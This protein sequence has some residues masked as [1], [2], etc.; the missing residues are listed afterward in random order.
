MLVLAGNWA[1]EMYKVT[2]KHT[3]SKL[4]ISLTGSDGNST[5]AHISYE[6]TAI[7]TSGNKFVEEFTDEWYEDLMV[8]W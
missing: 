7:G 2:P 3:V 8:E 1:L 6:I 5:K 4:E